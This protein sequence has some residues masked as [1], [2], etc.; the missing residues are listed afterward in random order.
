MTE[1]LESVASESTLQDSAI[2]G[3]IKECAPLL[4]FAHPFAGFLGVDLS[5][6]P[7]VE[8]FSAPHRVAKVDL[9]VVRL[10]YICHRCGN[11]AFRHYGVSFSQQRFADHSNTCPLGESFNGRAK[12]STASPDNQHVIFVSLVF[13][14][15]SS[16]KSLITPVDSRRT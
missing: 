2:L 10:I 6:A 13:A 14:G 9:P 4:Q 15:H 16:L 5:H 3:A 11:T 7:V 8:K 12:A 1:T